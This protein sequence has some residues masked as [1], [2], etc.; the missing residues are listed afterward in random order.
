MKPKTI[1]QENDKLR[2]HN[3][4]LEDRLLAVTELLH[5]IIAKPNSKMV[6]PEISRLALADY[7]AFLLIVEH[8]TVNKKHTMTSH[9]IGRN[10]LA[11]RDYKCLENTLMNLAKYG[12]IRLE[13]G[14]K[15]IEVYIENP[16]VFQLQEKINRSRD[17]RK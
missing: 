15:Y 6:K 11:E 13:A 12:L 17:E 4:D 10:V 7:A 1:E 2:E 8:M 16:T 9:S 14:K 5:H 3:M